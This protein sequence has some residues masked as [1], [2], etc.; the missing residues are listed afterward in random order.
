MAKAWTDLAKESVRSARSYFNTLAK[1]L[2]AIGCAAD[3]A[4]YVI[5]GL[6]RTGGNGVELDWRFYSVLSGSF[7]L[8]QEAEVAASFLDEANCLGARG[9]SEEK[10]AKLREIRD[11]RFPKSH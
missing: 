2:K 10:K 4:P 8:S 7:N 3:G 5:G 11:R 1:A 9:L 6:I